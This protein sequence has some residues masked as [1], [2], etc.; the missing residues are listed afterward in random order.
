MATSHIRRGAAGVIARVAGFA[1]WVG[2]ASAVAC[3]RGPIELGFWIEPVSYVSPRLGDPITAT[4][5]AGIETIARAE[6]ATAFERFDVVVSGNR[7][8]RYHVRVVQ[9]LL[10][11]RF[12]SREVSV[13]GESRGAA[14]WGG[15][16]AV[17]FDFL[18]GSAMVYAPEEI[19]RAELVAA[20]GRGIG[21]SAVHEFAHQ[22]LPSTPIHDTRDRASYEFESAARIEQYFGDMR[23]DVARPLLEHRLRRR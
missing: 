23:W 8:A 9:R 20:I 14:G 17:S 16:G 10:D 1:C 22:L 7:Q 18:A 4:E 11:Q 12:R 19:G 15:S 3:T 2:L 5:L 21:R 6:I 13:A